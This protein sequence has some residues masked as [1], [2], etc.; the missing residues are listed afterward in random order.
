ME[1]VMEHA[2]CQAFNLSLLCISWGIWC[3]LIHLSLG[4]LLPPWIKNRNSTD[5]T[6][7]CCR[8]EHCVSFLVNEGTNRQYDH[9]HIYQCSFSFVD[10]S[11]SSSWC[12]NRL[13]CSDLAPMSSNIYNSRWEKTGCSKN[14]WP[15]Y[16]VQLWRKY[17]FWGNRCDHV[18]WISFPYK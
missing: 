14:C 2:N 1:I 7:G 10:R 5:L 11:P 15:M 6:N 12:A 16:H 8:L 18:Y 4:Q 17:W 9:K 3:K 13:C